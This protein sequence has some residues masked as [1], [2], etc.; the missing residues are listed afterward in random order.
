MDNR[1]FYDI[2]SADFLMLKG[3]KLLQ[4]GND[5]ISNAFIYYQYSYFVIC[6]K[7]CFEKS[8][9]VKSVPEKKAM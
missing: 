6:S 7:N 5:Q 3:N 8:L 2:D 9:S 4:I 1:N